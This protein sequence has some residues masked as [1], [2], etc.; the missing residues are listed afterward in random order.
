MKLTQVKLAS[1]CQHPHGFAQSVNFQVV[2]QFMQQE[3][4]HVGVHRG[5]GLA[6]RH[7]V[8][9]QVNNAVGKVAQLGLGMI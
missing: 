9:F 3:K 1:G 7:R 6:H 5:V 2:W 8:V 4:H